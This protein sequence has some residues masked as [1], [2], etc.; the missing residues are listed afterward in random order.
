MNNFLLVLCTF[1]FLTA[2]EGKAQERASLASVYYWKA[3]PGKIEEYN[4]YIQQVAE[5]IDEEARKSGAFISVTTY[6]SQRD[7]SLW[8]HMRMFLLKDSVQLQNLSK[9]LEVAGEK[10]EPDE[11]K[12]KRRSEYSARLRDPAGQ[13]VLKV[14]K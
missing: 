8:T 6:V 3:K 4:R 12:R 7:S 5:P 10:L 13:E 11:G 1:L 2:I 14:L 9:A